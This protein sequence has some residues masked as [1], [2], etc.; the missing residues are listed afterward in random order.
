MCEKEKILEGISQWTKIGVED[1]QKINITNGMKSK[2]IFI[3]GKMKD[4]PIK[5]GIDQV[6][7][8]ISYAQVTKIEDT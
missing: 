4:I 1:L 7:M 8:K 3:I 6:T 5:K 2:A